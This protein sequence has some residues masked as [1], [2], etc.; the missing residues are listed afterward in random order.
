MLKNIYFL[1]TFSKAH[2]SIFST[3]SSRDCWNL[4]LTVGAWYFLVT[5]LLFLMW[6][7]LCWPVTSAWTRKRFDT[8]WTHEYTH[9]FTHIYCDCLCCLWIG[10]NVT[11]HAYV[12]AMML[13]SSHLV[14][15]LN[16]QVQD[17]LTDLVVVL[18]Q[19]LVNLDCWQMY[20]Y[21]RKAP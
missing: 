19:E 15:A 7:P 4:L 10:I 17:I 5:V 9:P 8:I 20:F 21:P 16:E 6:P 14:F 12:D 2:L 1:W 3:S 11:I 18:I 13:L